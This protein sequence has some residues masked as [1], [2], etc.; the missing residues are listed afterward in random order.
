MRKTV[1]FDIIEKRS[2]WIS[3]IKEVQSYVLGPQRISVKYN[4]LDREGR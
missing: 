1:N 3:V 2:D 4:L